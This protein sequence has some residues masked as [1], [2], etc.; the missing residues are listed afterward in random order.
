MDVWKVVNLKDYGDKILPL[1]ELFFR[2]FKHPDSGNMWSTVYFRWKLINNPVGKGLLSCAIYGDEIIGTA[3]MTLKRIWLNQITMIGA[4]TGDTFTNSEFSKNGKKADVYY[5]KNASLPRSKEYID[6]SVMGRLLYENTQKAQEDNINIIYGTPNEQSLAGYI[7]KLDYYCHSDKIVH[8]MK[9]TVLFMNI[10]LSRYFGQLNKY[11]KF[12]INWLY[13]LNKIIENMYSKYWKFRQLSAGYSIETIGNLDE[14]FD[15]FWNRI[16]HQYQFSLVKDREYFCYRFIDTVHARYSIFVLKKK[17]EIFG[18]LVTR[19]ITS[20][21]GSKMCYIAD[22]LIDKTRQN[23][24][25]Y[26]LSH[27]VNK[28]LRDDISS[29][30]TWVVNK[31]LFSAF[32]KLGF[33]KYSKTPII[34]FKSDLGEQIKRLDCLDLTM[35]FSDSI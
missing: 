1:V 24:L 22:W 11:G 29:F 15:S 35:A 13:K 18:I 21:D 3:S 9:P 12:I 7:K 23:I 33:M 26:L 27:V 20:S 30:R 25:T 8:L 34:F 19:N 5:E 4:E 28:A 31:N 16:K 6:V 17:H 32:Y 2:Q 10:I 14:S